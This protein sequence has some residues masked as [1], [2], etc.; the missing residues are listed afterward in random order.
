MK[1]PLKIQCFRN[2]LESLWNRASRMNLFILLARFGAAQSLLPPLGS[3]PMAKKQIRPGQ[4]PR[5]AWKTRVSKKSA[6]RYRTSTQRK[7][8]CNTG[9]RDAARKPESVYLRNLCRECARR[10]K[11]PGAACR[12]GLKHDELLRR[13]SRRIVD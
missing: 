3:P 4:S 11:Y 7:M 8:K 1:G 6:S 5:H 12:F 10:A 13:P 2:Q 9:C